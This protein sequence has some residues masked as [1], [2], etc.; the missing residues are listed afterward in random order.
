MPVTDAASVAAADQLSRNCIAPDTPAISDLILSRIAAADTVSVSLPQLALATD[1]IKSVSLIWSP[2]INVLLI[3]SFFY[4]YH[5][6][7]P[8]PVFSVKFQLF[9][10]R[11]KHKTIA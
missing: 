10:H 9:H 11:K 5:S 2:L 8:F 3:I 4:Y 6:P 7:Q 1:L